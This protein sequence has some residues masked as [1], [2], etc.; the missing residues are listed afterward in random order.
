MGIVY[1][2][3]DERLGRQ[4]AIKMIHATTADPLA[5]ERLWREARAAARV[6][7]P[8][9][10]Q[11]YE[12][13]EEAGEP[14]LVMELLA[15]ESLAARL[16]R[17]AL[18]LAE[19]IEIT[20]ALLAALSVLHQN[21]ILH[22]DLKPS[23]VFLTPHGL[24]LL[25]FGLARASGALTAGAADATRP[26]AD[27]SLTM[28]GAFIGTPRYASP[29]QLRGEEID[30][31]ADLFAVGAMLYE[32]LA[33]RP[34]FNGETPLEVC[35]AI[36]NQEPPALAG[37]PA[38]AAAHRII[39]RALAKKRDERVASAEVLAEELRAIL[40]A[41]PAGA[42]P[43]PVRAVSRL[44][45]LPFRLLRPD[46]E[47]DYLAWSLADAIAS[48]LSGIASLQVRSSLAAA[49]FAGGEAAA[50]DLR[51]V[52]AEGEVDTVLTGTLLRAGDGIRVTAQL[53]AVPAGTILAAHN[54]TATLR[55]LFTLESEITR[56]VIESLSLPLTQRE[57]RLI[58]HDVPAS[59]T[60]YE[61]YLRAIQ[62]GSGLTQWLVARDL[63]AR[64]VEEDSSYAPAWARLARCHWLIGKYGGDRAPDYAAAEAALERAL[65][66]NPELALAHNIY[67]HVEASSGR[68]LEATRRLLGRAAAQQND[69]QV[70]AGLVLSLR[71][72]GLLDQSI[73]AHHAARRLDPK[74]PTSVTQ[75]YFM[76]GDHELGLAESAHDIGYIGALHL[77]MMGRIGE[78]LARL[79]KRE[80]DDEDSH[81]MAWIVSLRAH[82]EG[83]RAESLA[84]L[85]KLAAGFP[86]PEGLYYVGRH[87][88]FAGE[89]ERALEV[90]GRAV[91]MGFHCH[92]AFARDPW[93]DPLRASPAFGELARAAETHQRSAA[94]AFAAGGGEGVLD[95]GGV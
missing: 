32:M 20:R 47:I 62:Q 22:R 33:G 82:L 39:A 34:A 11:I 35:H 72:S 48:S 57:E 30:G 15:G 50:P 69:P 56:R 25:D 83:K 4:V 73:A 41:A 85:E 71:F 28:P 29:E 90:L 24:K 13:G 75:T 86:D 76:R 77:V 67:A 7:H 14:Y 60:A 54:S 61:F 51:A 93:L 53:V 27:P 31:R 8:S 26:P 46:P 19:A 70:F 1:A 12:I 21:G 68:A 17:G 36:L 52:A 63:L 88:A 2:A 38:A 66:L 92:P 49:R 94:A 42:T 87:F 40:A 84:A 64:S 44:M 6:N 65:A 79:K 58:R 43:A 55:D 95:S 89:P 45:V 16:E 10:C 80:R 37:S 3:R 23:N 74:V 59:A 91:E 81:I 9:I 5:R 78:A 18:P